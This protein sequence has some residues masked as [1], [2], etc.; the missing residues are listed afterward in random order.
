MLQH[1][2]TDAARRFAVRKM[3]QAFQQLMLIP[4]GEVLL[5]V[6]RF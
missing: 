3:S 2:G 1:G 4:S 5:L 6:L